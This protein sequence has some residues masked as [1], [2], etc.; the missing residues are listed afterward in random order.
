MVRVVEKAEMK[1]NRKH[2]VF[3]Q[4]PLGSVDSSIGK[5]AVYAPSHK[6]TTELGSSCGSSIDS[7]EPIEFAR[8]LLTYICYPTEALSEDES[9][10]DSPKLARQDVD[11][12][13]EDEV[14]KIAG[15][16]LEHEEYLYRKLVR[17]TKTDSGD[18]PVTSASYGEIE[19][20]R[21][22]GESN[23][24][25]LHRLHVLQDA[26]FKRQMESLTKSILS[27]AK[28][29][30]DLS[31]KI[32][33]TLSLGESLSRIAKQFELGGIRGAVVNP[34]K[35]PEPQPEQFPQP[36][37]LERARI[38][39]E[40]IE[41]TRLAPFEALQTRL[42]EIIEL[43]GKS[44]EFATESNMT[45][46]RIATEIKRSSDTTTALARWSIFWTVVVL[47]V[48]VTGLGVDCHGRQQARVD[49]QAFTELTRVISTDLKAIAPAIDLERTTSSAD[50]NAI[51]T[52][53]K[54]NTAA[55]A[56][57]QTILVQHA[58]LIAQQN[59]EREANKH[60]IEALSLKVDELEARIQSSQRFNPATSP[61]VPSSKPAGRP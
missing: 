11:R 4:K 58:A 30:S 17:E 53:A 33:G 19:H 8:R 25:Y 2:V 16:Y 32:E 54:K 21:N 40:A 52:E 35:H 61:A 43:N 38:D 60:L 45:Q 47:L 18:K 10:P 55:E 44:I 34:R 51:L 28:F 31:K 14:D 56:A 26:A 6:D 23:I 9:K 3:V 7:C 27:G 39:Y 12:L 48:T 15:L 36:P 5:L 13:T 49:S 37:L 22:P 50:L 57:Y 42:D 46:T 1:I 24:Q 41:R 20:P 59:E 29:S